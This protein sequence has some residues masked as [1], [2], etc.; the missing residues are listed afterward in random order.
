MLLQT[1]TFDIKFYTMVGKI[2][3]CV[4]FQS[5]KSKS[6]CVRVSISR[7]ALNEVIKKTVFASCNRDRHACLQNKINDTNRVWDLPSCWSEHPACLPG[8]KMEVEPDTVFHHPLRTPRRFVCYPL[9]LK[10][11]M[12]LFLIT[13]RKN[14]LMSYVLR[15]CWDGGGDVVKVWG[16]VRKEL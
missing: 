9:R 3:A 13:S 7:L 6:V 1:L 14:S 11:Q 5:S 12:F 4:E 10:L 16:G 8:E 2:K 15:C